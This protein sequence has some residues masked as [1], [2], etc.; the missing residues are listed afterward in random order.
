[1]ESI[2]KILNQ[3]EKYVRHLFVKVEKNQELTTKLNN[4][5]K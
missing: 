1:M 2:K 3:D 4:E 5:K